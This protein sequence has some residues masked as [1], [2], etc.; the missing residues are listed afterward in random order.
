MEN[1]YYNI[2]NITINIAALFG[3][4]FITII[5]GILFCNVGLLNRVR[6]YYYSRTITTLAKYWLTWAMLIA[7]GDLIFKTPSVIIVLGITGGYL[8]LISKMYVVFIYLFTYFALGLSYMLFKN[9]NKGISTNNQ[10]V[11]KRPLYQIL[12][13]AF[14]PMLTVALCVYLS[15]PT[16]MFLSATM[17]ILFFMVTYPILMLTLIEYVVKLRHLVNFTRTQ[18]STENTLAYDYALENARLADEAHKRA[19]EAE[20]ARIETMRRATKTRQR[21]QNKKAKAY[22]KLTRSDVT[23]SWLLNNMSNPSRPNNKH[24]LSTAATTTTTTKVR[25]PQKPGVVHPVKSNVMYKLT[26]LAGIAENHT[27]T[28]LHTFDIETMTSGGVQV[29]A[30]ITM[31]NNNGVKVF[32]I[33]DFGDSTIPLVTR[34]ERMMNEFMEVLLKECVKGPNVFYA[35]NLGRF[36]G[37]LILQHL[38]RLYGTNVRLLVDESN[39]IINI[40][41]T[42]EGLGLKNTTLNFKDSQRFFNFTLESLATQFGLAGKTQPWQKVWGAEHFHFELPTTDPAWTEFVEYAIQDSAVLLKI[43]HITQAKFAKEYNVE[44]GNAFSTSSL[45]NIVFRTAFLKDPIPMLSPTEDAIIRPAYFSGAVDAYMPNGENLHV[46]DVNSM[47]SYAMLMGVP[48]DYLGV[49]Y[50]LNNL[51]TF[52]GFAYAILTFNGDGVPVAPFRQENGKVIYP[53]GQFSGTYFSEEL[54][55]LRA[56]GYKVEVVRAHHFS[57][58]YPFNN[59]VNHFY[60]L[61]KNAVGPDRVFVKLMLN[62]LYGYF[63]QASVRPKTM[64]LQ[65]PMINIISNCCLILEDKPLYGE[66]S[67]VKYQ[68]LQ[69]TK[70]MLETVMLLTPEHRK[71]AMKLTSVSYNTKCHVGIS[72]AIGSNGRNHM[73][74]FKA[75]PGNPPYYSD[76]DCVVLGKPLSPQHI[77]TGLGQMKD[78]LGT[79][80]TMG[81]FLGPKNYFLEW[82]DPKTK[83]V[84]IRAVFAGV[85][86]NLLS[87]QDFLDMADNKEITIKENRDMFINNRNTNTIKVVPSPPKFLVSTN[88]KRISTV[89]NAYIPPHVNGYDYKSLWQ[90][91]AWMQS[92]IK[93][94]IHRPR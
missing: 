45:A 11:A 83:A 94:A 79:K 53:T 82:I 48:T 31:A 65:Q 19:I 61:K 24:Y 38:V 42:G 37:W 15:L 56:Y 64:V 88:T 5:L 77:G 90:V 22:A 46:Y 47:Y 27:P 34:V 84:K 80:A 29:P 68:P 9:P 7:Q 91:K 20:R 85:Q 81:I 16:N 21:A 60:E 72:A 74:P 23:G 63:G 87:K 8:F 12:L 28:T 43:L 30:L 57:K 33:R 54:K 62:S 49:S 39:A 78:E 6:V 67:L 58:T 69:S 66:Y 92:R 71:E 2:Q 76:T 32:K 44:F 41:I 1:L 35:H 73:T 55:T 59:Y 70:F 86:R 4:S 89:T 93:K 40:T 17:Q 14:L 26:P 10:N 52:Y 36:D 51:E 25:V 18:A 3:F 75:I 13:I 50:K